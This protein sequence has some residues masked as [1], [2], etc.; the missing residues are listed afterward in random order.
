MIVIVIS[1]CTAPEEDKV[2]DCVMHDWQHHAISNSDPT[3]GVDE[4]VNSQ[5]Q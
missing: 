5:N 3:T 4:D 2:I 1:S